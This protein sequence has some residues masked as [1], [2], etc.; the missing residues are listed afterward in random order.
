MNSRSR[1]AASPSSVRGSLPPR[2]TSSSIVSK[3]AARPCG[4]RGG[5]S[6]AKKTFAI[7]LMDP[8]YESEN[9]TTAFRILSVMAQRG[10]NI[11]VFAYEG[12]A[13]LAFAAQA[14]H[15]NPVHGKNL[16]EENHPTTKDQVVALLE[17]AR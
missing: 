17:L 13:A 8:P 15:P 10:H 16:A 3:P 1:S 11:N 5:G 14:P 2:L 7:A 4:I 9:L 12:A 6:M